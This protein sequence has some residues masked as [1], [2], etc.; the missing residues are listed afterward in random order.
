MTD[1]DDADLAVIEPPML[2]L[3]PDLRLNGILIVEPRLLGKCTN[4]TK[5]SQIVIVHPSA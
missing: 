4:L 2:L 1:L 5:Q 3:P